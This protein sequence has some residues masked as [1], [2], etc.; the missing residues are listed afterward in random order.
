[1]NAYTSI[2]PEDRIARHMRQ[3]QHLAELAIGLADLAAR[4]AEAAWNQ[5]EPAAK[6]PDFALIVTR[7]STAARQA[8]ALEA[9]LAG[10]KFPGS[11]AKTKLPPSAEKPAPPDPRRDV[12]R[13]AFDLFTAKSP[14]RK[15]L[16]SALQ[17]RIDQ[18][19]AA[20]PEG[21]MTA[22]KILRKIV[23]DFDIEADYAKFPDELLEAITGR[24]MTDPMP[25]YDGWDSVAWATGNGPPPPN[26]RDD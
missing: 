14:N 4:K 3:L 21:A 8:M 7:L 12:L 11:G 18:D 22:R 6:T 16:R 2:E 20:D 13:Q 5:P 15:E 25:Q 10:A 9:K 17:A 19:L 23:E 24:K 26:V 1:M